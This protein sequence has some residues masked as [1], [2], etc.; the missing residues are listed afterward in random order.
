MGF[1]VS[2][3]DVYIIEKFCNKIITANYQILNNLLVFIMSISAFT[4]APFTKIIYRN[5]ENSM[6]KS[7]KTLA[8]IGLFIVPIGLII[9]QAITIWFLKSNLPLLFFGIAFLYVY[10]SYIYGLD[11][12]NLFK[13]H[14]EKIVII[15]LSIGVIINSALSS[16]FLHLNYGITG[17]LLGSAIAQLIVMVLFKLVNPLLKRISAH[18]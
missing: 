9:I 6:V 5:T 14:Q 15:N 3:I 7:K 1:L 18:D 12:V 4:Y 13:Q 16:L 2:R 11:I 17:V 8:L 10:P